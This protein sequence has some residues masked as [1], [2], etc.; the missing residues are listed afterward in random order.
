VNSE[1][2]PK[3]DSR[4]T[5]GLTII[6]KQ[7]GDSAVSPDEDENFDD[8]GAEKPNRNQR[9]RERTRDSILQAA[10]RV[11][12]RKGV[13]GA[14]V[15]DVTEEADV[16]YGS[17][18][19]HFKTMDDVVAAVAEK[20]IK[21]VVDKTRQILMG[22]DRVELLPSIGARVVMRI[23]NQDPAIRWLLE[24]P[25]IFVAEFYKMAGSFMRSAEKAAVADGTFKP[26][27]GHEAWLRIFPWLLVS[28]LNEAL[29][30]GDILGQ[31]DRFAL[32]SMSLLG[33][34]R[35]LAPKLLESSRKLVAAAGLSARSRP[36]TKRKGGRRGGK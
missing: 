9:R 4:N 19:N 8:T 5:K 11:F 26:V 12:R 7:R 28:E 35:A 10:D 15:N 36:P 14:S 32:I 22:A 33:M 31:E 29:A 17:F 2:P 18:Y 21:A 34:D 27:G 24:R 25:Y 16:A 13:S 3:S 30:T 1:S 20:T 6:A 23:L